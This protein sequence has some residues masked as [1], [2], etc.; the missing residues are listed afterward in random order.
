MDELGGRR[1]TYNLVAVSELE[2]QR[3]LIAYFACRVLK[4]LQVASDEVYAMR[5]TGHEE[6]DSLNSLSERCRQ[7]RRR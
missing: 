2:A 7:G 3:M 4:N 1:Q 6:L 5:R